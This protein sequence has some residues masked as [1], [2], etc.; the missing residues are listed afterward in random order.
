MMK[1]RKMKAIEEKLL[2]A[3]QNAKEMDISLAELKAMLTLLY[4]EDE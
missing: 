4:T 2:V 3:I 1:E